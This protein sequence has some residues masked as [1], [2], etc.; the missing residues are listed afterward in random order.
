VPD[1][2]P[3]FDANAG[4]ALRQIVPVSDRQGAS[5]VDAH[6]GTPRVGGVHIVNVGSV[7]EAPG[8]SSRRSKALGGGRP[9]HSTLVGA[10]PPLLPFSPDLRTDLAISLLLWSE[11]PVGDR[12]SGPL[13]K[14]FARRL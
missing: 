2:A 5:D 4:C 7:G 11:Q 13:S 14:P 9:V 12:S 3:V 6:Q 8:V 10:L 1:R